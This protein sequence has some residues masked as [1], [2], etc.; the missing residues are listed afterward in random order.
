MCEE[1]VAKD[2]KGTQT[3]TFLTLSG[4]RLFSFANSSNAFF[5]ALRAWTTFC[6][7]GGGGTLDRPAAA[8]PRTSP[9]TVAGG[10]FPP[11]TME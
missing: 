2:E 5:L 9:P 8:P 11:V 7:D 1:G 10:F 4:L 6:P 3:R